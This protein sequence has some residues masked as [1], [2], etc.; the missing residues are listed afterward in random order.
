[1]TADQVIDQIKAL[2]PKEQAAVV[3][4]VRQIGASLKQ[5]PDVQTIDRSELEAS[6]E[7]IFD[8]Y[9]NLFRKLAQ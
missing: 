6:A 4:F 5:S 7:Q 2:S 8:R 1:M 9:D 3:D